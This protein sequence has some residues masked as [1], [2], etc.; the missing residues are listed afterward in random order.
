M[1]NIKVNLVRNDKNILMINIGSQRIIQL[2]VDTS[3]PT[4]CKLVPEMTSKL[5]TI[6]NHEVNSEKVLKNYLMT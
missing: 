5:R 2:F 6:P 3:N 1:L 4:I